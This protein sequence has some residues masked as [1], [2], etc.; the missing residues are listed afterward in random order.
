M[1]VI[2]R[3]SNWSRYASSTD[4]RHNSLWLDH[5]VFHEHRQAARAFDWKSPSAPLMWELDTGGIRPW[6][7]LDTN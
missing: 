1:A 4:E 5:A 2:I 7:K 6:S 3:E